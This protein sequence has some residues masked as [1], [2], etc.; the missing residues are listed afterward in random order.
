VIVL[1]LFA[2][3]FG[4]PLVW[5]LLAP[6]KSDDA[7]FSASPLAFGSLGQVGTAWQHLML[8]NDGEITQWAV[9]SVFYSV[10]GVLL[11]VLACVP[12]GYVF[13][14]ATF[15]GRK[16]VLLLTLVSMI[17]PGS[18]L[19]MPQF[20]EMNAVHLIDTP[21]AV[22]LPAAFF[23]FGVYLCYVYFATSVSPELLAAGRIDGCSEFRLFWSIALPLAKPIIG[24]IAF[25]SFV[26]SWNNYFGV[27]VMLTNDRM[28]NLPAGLG[29]LISSTPALNPALGA[30]QLPIR[31]PEAALAGLIVVLPIVIMFLF[32]QRFVRAGFLAGSEK[33]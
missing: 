33:G 24:F 23:P 5:L 19:V 2:L 1:L 14:T 30:S 28:Y 15:I 29:T 31:R 32:S 10:S 7:L 16:P 17:M 4:L 9:N 3:F 11:A 6:T 20:L 22:I 26:G 12:A 27:I 8:Y 25:F 18:A 21:W 13:G